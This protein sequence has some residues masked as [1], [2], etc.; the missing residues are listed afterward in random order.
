VPFKSVKQQHYLAV[1]PDKIGGWSKF[2]E[3]S[4]ATNFKKLPEKVKKEDKK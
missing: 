1:H 3:W 2:K 4:A